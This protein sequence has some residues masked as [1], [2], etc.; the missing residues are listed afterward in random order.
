MAINYNFVEIYLIE[1]NKTFM[2]DKIID[3]ECSYKMIENILQKMELNKIKFNKRELKI[4]KHQNLIYENI[5]NDRTN[6]YEVVP[7]DVSIVQERSNDLV[8]VKYSKKKIKIH[9]FPFNK[10]VDDI[11]SVKTIQYKLSDVYLNIETEIRDGKS[12]NKAYFTA[13]VDDNDSR[14]S[15]DARIKKVLAIIRE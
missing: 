6:I 11:Y 5:N 1:K 3:I 2:N 4:Y 12:I 13:C 8:E 7:I 14:E 15:I 10:N 9:S